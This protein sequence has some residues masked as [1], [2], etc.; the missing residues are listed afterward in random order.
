MQ[1]T[2]VQEK[3]EYLIGD[4]A[5]MVGLSRDA[6]RFY[7]KKGIINARKKDNGYRYYSEDD[8]YKLMY[9]LYQRKMNTSLEEIEGL[10]SGG[11][12][13]ESRRKRIKQRMAEEEETIRMHQQAIA[14]LKLVQKDMD[15]IEESLNRYSLRRFPKAYIMG[16]CRD[17][18]HGLREWFRLASTISGLDMTYVYNELTYNGRELTQHGT[19]L[20]FYKE[21]ED[22]LG[23]AFDSS[24][25]ALTEEKMCIYTVL[26]SRETLPS[27]EM[28][29]RMVGWGRKHG[30]EAGGRVYAND[31]TSFFDEDGATFCLELYMPV[32][33]IVSQI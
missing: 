13:M 31:M 16:Q 5:R 26:T 25:Y 14:R 22:Q 12:S 6:L 21:L 18:Q 7:E 4:V 24:R 9:I 19:Q 20:L 11:R 2:N 3:A 30:I 33:K 1:K 23:D 29:S 32:R 28:V 17:L 27:P 8:I 10:M 15:H